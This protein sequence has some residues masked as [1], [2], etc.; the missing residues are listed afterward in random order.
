MKST[1]QINHPSHYGG[2]NNPYEA[3][4][5]IEAWK[6]GFNLGNVVK[7]ISR[8]DKKQNTLQDLQKAGWYLNREIVQLA[9][10]TQDPSINKVALNSLVLH[11][12]L[13][14]AID[15]LPSSEMDTD[16]SIEYVNRTLSFGEAKQVIKINQDKSHWKVYVSI[17][18]LKRLAELLSKIDDQPI[19]VNFQNS[20][21]QI[22]ISNIL[23]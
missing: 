14:K 3:I 12:T 10:E 6:L 4:K 5:V 22:E 13:S 21:S 23:I 2:A 20:E 7:Y 17:G 15:L 18:K 16:I 11:A 8:A 1:E 9:T 19:V